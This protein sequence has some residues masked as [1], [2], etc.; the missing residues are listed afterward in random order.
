MNI[1]DTVVGLIKQ[2]SPDELT[3]LRLHLSAY[4]RRG[5]KFE[6][7]AIPLFNLITDRKF[8]LRYKV[9][10]EILY[11]NGNESAFS[12]FLIRFRDKIEEA[13]LLDINIKR[14]EIYTPRQ[15]AYI[16][17]TKS[18]AL[19][20]V[21]ISRNENVQAIRLLKNTFEKARNIEAFS[22]S[23]L[24][25]DILFT[26]PEIYQNVYSKRIINQK[27]KVD[28]QYDKLY[29][30]KKLWDNLFKSW[31]FADTMHISKESI[32]N[33]LTIQ[34]GLSSL[35]S[36]LYTQLCK[37]YILKNENQ[38]KKGALLLKHNDEKISESPH[39]FPTELVIQNAICRLDLLLLSYRFNEILDVCKVYK[40][41]IF[42]WEREKRK[43]QEMEFWANLYLKNYDQAG[44]ILT[45][46]IESLNNTHEQV[47][48][49]RIWLGQLLILKGLYFEGADL[50]QE[51][52]LF[53][54][55]KLQPST[56]LAWL[57]VA[58]A[59]Y[60]KKKNLLH[61]ELYPSKYFNRIEKLEP[62]TKRE[63][64]VKSILIE[65]FETNFDFKA[66]YF[67][68]Q[69]VFLE[70]AKF[71]S[72]VCWK[73]TENELIPFNTFYDS[74]RSNIPLEMNIP[75]R[76]ELEITNENPRKFRIGVYD[77]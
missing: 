18:I 6:G 53:N 75:V 8:T 54:I 22:E 38:F 68:K 45:E 9:A 55:A 10:L 65:L 77:V 21:Y 50:L 13:Y 25:I 61:S 47:Y 69:D 71:N 73:I 15:Q 40:S 36:E 41:N 63:S 60:L 26:I 23:V 24:I 49:Y 67:R 62:Q 30:L 59:L 52:F 39:I 46:L 72:N 12:R 1:F 43:I 29:N 20:H 27:E 51:L 7:K 66:V 16:H 37:A 56:N 42:L 2:M 48:T 44:Y 11:P 35:Q 58:S 34:S 17:I 28:K 57:F 76:N 5:D 32:L 64:V 70:L 3:V 14:N 33:K 19:A 74:L 4:D 31:A